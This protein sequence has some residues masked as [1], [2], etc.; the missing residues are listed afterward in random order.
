MGTIGGEAHDDDALPGSELCV[1][2]EAGQVHADQRGD[3]RLPASSP[4]HDPGFPKPLHW[5]GL[6]ARVASVDLALLG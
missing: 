6:S 3:P 4:R 1:L 5:R 2:L